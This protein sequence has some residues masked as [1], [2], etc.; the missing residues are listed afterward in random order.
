M[1]GRVETKELH[2]E[3]AAASRRMISKG[4]P[5]RAEYL[6]WE[7]LRDAPRAATSTYMLGV[8]ILLQRRFLDARRLIDRAYRLKPTVQD[9]FIA[10]DRAGLLREAAESQPDWDWPCYQ[11]ERDR[12][13]AEGLTLDAAR[14]HRGS[15]VAAAP[16]EGAEIV[17]VG[18]RG[19]P[20]ADRLALCGRL[21]RAGFAWRFEETHVLAIRRDAFRDAFHCVDLL[22]LPQEPPR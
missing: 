11:L 3:L 1:I 17:H 14:A 18:F 20:V 2:S 4:K 15:E 16:V 12:W 13:S 19:L 21:D 22:A 6:L 9:R 7:I 8:S 5:R 10:P